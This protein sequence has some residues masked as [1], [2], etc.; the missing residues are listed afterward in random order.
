MEG[1][2]ISLAHRE[3]KKNLHS[4][5]LL[6]KMVLD[7]MIL[8]VKTVITFFRVLYGDITDMSFQDGHG[9]IVGSDGNIRADTSFVCLASLPASITT[10]WRW[11][12]RYRSFND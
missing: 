8:A 10:S 3:I 7:P 2:D 12:F 5:L 1:F 11:K 9:G 4:S 6:M